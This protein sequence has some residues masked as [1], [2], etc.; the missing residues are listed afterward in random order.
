[1]GRLKLETTSYSDNSCGA[2]NYFCFFLNFLAY[3]LFLV[4]FIVVRCQIADLEWREGF[5][6]YVC[7]RGIPD[8]V[9]NR[10][11]VLNFWTRKEPR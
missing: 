11:N 4:G 1:M 2:T 5:F 3:S 9:Q 10:V 6:A 8:P 7:Y